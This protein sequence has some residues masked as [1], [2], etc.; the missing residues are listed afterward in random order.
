MV[1][2]AVIALFGQ[3]GELPDKAKVEANTR[4]IFR[5]A[6]AG[7]NE[8]TRAELYAHIMQH[9]KVRFITSCNTAR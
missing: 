4:A 3:S 5:E 7:D 8:V 1:K 6:A 9:S 2:R